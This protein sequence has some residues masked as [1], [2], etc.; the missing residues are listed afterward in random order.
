MKTFASCY[1]GVGG[2]DCGFCAAG[3]TLTWQC[4]AD[5][6]R[7]RVLRKRFGAPIH[8]SIESLATVPELPRVDLLYGELPDHRIERW[9][10]PLHYVAQ[11]LKPSWLLCEMSPTVPCDRVLID[12]AL[13]GWSIRLMHLRAVITAGGMT[14]SDTD[15]RN[16]ALVLAARDPEQLKAVRLAGNYAEI[17]IRGEDITHER[18]SLPWHEEGRGFRAG[19]T[20]GCA[21]TPCSCSS[22]QRIAALADAT[23]P[24]LSNWLAEALDGR[25]SDG[26][27][28]QLTHAD[29]AGA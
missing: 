17:V 29:G 12:L 9:W 25:W 4:E 28:R 26:V 15:V 16:R 24:Y 27:V 22:E 1:T 19:W 2:A 10:S 6:Y 21:D 13:S 8:N 23:S 3:W 18:L 20:C 7:R 11:I 5:E 14:A